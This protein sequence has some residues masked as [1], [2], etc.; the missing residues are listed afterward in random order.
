MKTWKEITSSQPDTSERRAAYEQGRQEVVAEIV[1]YNLAELRK[2]RSVTQVELARQLGVAQPT[3]SGLERR[4]DFQL[5]TLRDYIEALGGHL[6]ISAIFDD[7]RVPMTMLFGDED[8]PDDERGASA[9]A[10]SAE[11]A[12]PGTPSAK[13]PYP[14]RL[15]SARPGGKEEDNMTTSR[16]TG[17][18]AASAASKVL[19]DKRTSPTSKRAAASALSQAA[20]KRSS[21]RS[22]R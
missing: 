2:L 22:S 15:F 10:H 20:P 12:G 7:I 4:S 5:S 11:N 9:L 13:A 3:L 19:R 17:R 14:G 8:D 16:H 1:A 21:R 6:E 18:A